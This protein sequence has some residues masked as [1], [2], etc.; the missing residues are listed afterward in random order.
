[1]QY[2][3]IV[4]VISRALASLLVAKN[5]LEEYK[6]FFLANPLKET[7]I[8]LCLNESHPKNTDELVNA[9][10]EEYLR[11]VIFSVNAYNVH[12]NPLS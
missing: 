5:I 1:M 2:N 10:I 4:L 3:V 8:F 9:D 7:R 12:H 6:R 11:L